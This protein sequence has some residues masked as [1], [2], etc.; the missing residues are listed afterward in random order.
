MKSF[1]N[2]FLVCLLGLSVG[3]AVYIYQKQYSA[4]SRPKL[5]TKDQIVQK[6]AALPEVQK[7][8][9]ILQN[10]GIKTSMYIEAVP[11]LSNPTYAVYYGEVY[12]DHESRLA[13]FIVDPLTGAVFVGDIAGDKLISYQAWSKTCQLE[14]C[15][16][17]TAPV[18]VPT[19][20][21][22]KSVK[23]H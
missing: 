13:R 10:R 12:S 7:E 20:I 5:L 15:S 3:L 11:S 18:A 19:F 6:V 21:P 16:A 17:Y 23:K 1:L 9:L 22:Q 2:L 14:S 4:V 8:N